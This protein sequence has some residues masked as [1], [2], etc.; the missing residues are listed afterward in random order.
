MGSFWSA[1]RI[2]WRWKRTVLLGRVVN[3]AFSSVEAFLPTKRQYDTLD[4]AIAS[5]A[6]IAM[7]GRAC[8]WNEDGTV[9]SL[10]NAEVLAHWKIARAEVELRV[11]RLMWLQQAA[12][13]RN[14]NAQ[15]F[16]AIFG[17]ISGQAMQT[18]AD[19]GSLSSQA[20][21]WAKRAQEDVNQLIN[22]SEEA[23]S[24]L[25]TAGPHIVAWLKDP[26]FREDFYNIDVSILRAKE[27]RTNI[28]PPTCAPPNDY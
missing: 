15:L 16:A 18:V 6:R 26:N 28:P 21:P 19:D 1:A 13:D 12:K 14:N 9:R 17:T 3:S 23:Q 22:C 10:T 4:A 25:E 24:L 20:N 27:F 11:R 2:P 7:R 5:L 8:T